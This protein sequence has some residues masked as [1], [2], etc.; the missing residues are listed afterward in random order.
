M[1]FDK[2]GVVDLAQEERR[3]GK[4]KIKKFQ[5]RKNKSNMIIKPNPKYREQACR[6][7]Q[8]WWRELKI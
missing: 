3:K 7:I 5:S 6:L 8:N 2:G 1:R 4:Y